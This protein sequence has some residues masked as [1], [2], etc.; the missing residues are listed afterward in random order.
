MVK[1]IKPGQVWTD[2]DG[3]ERYVIA[4]PQGK[5]SKRVLWRRPGSHAAKEYSQTIAKFSA[6]VTICHISRK[7]DYAPALLNG[8]MATVEAVE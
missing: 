6:E 1:D 4:C 3:I 8:G 7:A 5:Y 2:A